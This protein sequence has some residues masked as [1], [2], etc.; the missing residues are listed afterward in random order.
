MIQ[1]ETTVLHRQ[2]QMEQNRILLNY[3]LRIWFKEQFNFSDHAGCREESERTLF[4]NRLT[5]VSVSVDLSDLWQITAHC[6]FSCLQSL[7]H[8]TYGQMSVSCS[9][10]ESRT[11]DVLLGFNDNLF[12]VFSKISESEI[13]TIQTVL[14]DSSKRIVF[15]NYWTF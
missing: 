9:G 14:D 13:K 15:T 10:A 7:W 11:P 4:R 3:F 8:F 6:S 1:R 2:E 5:V 12:D